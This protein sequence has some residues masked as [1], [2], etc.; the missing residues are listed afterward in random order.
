VQDRLGDEHEL[1]VPA[2]ERHERG[3][4]F[5]PFPV[6]EL[7]L[8][9]CAGDAPGVVMDPACGSGRFLMAARQ[10]WPACRVRGLETDPTALAVAR[11]NLPE[12]VLGPESFLTAAPTGD[13]DLLVG[14]PPY[15]RDRGHKRDLYVDFLEGAAA[16][17]RPGG[18]VAFVLSSAWL[19]V[20]YGKVVRRVLAEGFA[21]EWL[22][23][24][25]AERWFPGAKVNTMVLVAR[26]EDD[27]A[28]RSASEV[29]FATVTEP[30]PAP[31]RVG[32]QRKQALL[33]V[34]EPWGLWHRA[35]QVWL[36]RRGG[37][38]SL[39]AHARIQRGF[40]TNANG[41][42]YPPL[43]AAIEP[44]FLQTLL[45][46]PKRFAGV[47]AAADELPDRVFVCTAGRDELAAHGAVQAL[48]WLD[49]HDRGDDLR[50]WQLPP[51]VPSRLFLVKGYGDRFRQPV[52]DRP[53]YCDQQLYQVRPVNGVPDEALAALMNSSW[54]RLSLEL[55]GRVNFGDG[56]LWLGLQDARRIPI[57]DPTP[58]AAELVQAFAA[59]PDGRVPPLPQLVDDP[60]WARPMGALDDLVAELVGLSAAD[61]SEVA[62]AATALC[63]R[64][65]RKAAS[66]RNPRRAG[67]SK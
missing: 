31:A 54:F 36:D 5:T 8:G 2:A 63:E 47:R 38:S 50:S 12:G 24:S 59:L 23:E 17:L 33:S 18:R 25:S 26:R 9:L 65:L 43:A 56:V 29:R 19:D 11:E 35:P 45:K 3:Q 16:W 53:V 67:R 44:R 61:A 66:G 55:V 27:A 60:V 41:F 52:F 10:R 22:V 28:V 20:G 42:F 40:T 49:A 51:Q 30:L 48:A 14:N 32:R 39:G 57:P 46:S 58:R 6:I 7:V 21:I 1:T 34:D 13:V 64:R 37:L 62:A 15:V 4:Y